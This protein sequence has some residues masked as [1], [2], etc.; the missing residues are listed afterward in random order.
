MLGRPW[1]RIRRGGSTGRR[2]LQQLIAEDPGTPWA[3]YARERLQ[4]QE[5]VPEGRQLDINSSNLDRSMGRAITYFNQD[6]LDK[7]K[8]MLREISERFPEFSGAPQAL[9]A[10]ALCYY[11]EGDCAN[12]ITYYR[13]LVERYP[14]HNLVPEA[15]FHLG[16]CFEKTGNRELAL[17]AYRKIL[18]IAPDGA[19]GKQA[20]SKVKP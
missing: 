17:D 16:L 19:F 12:T 8:P 3:G 10:L 9:A 7:A 13:K 2:R 18:A 6:R 4:E 14:E 5:S 1:W 20:R 11:K 15:Y